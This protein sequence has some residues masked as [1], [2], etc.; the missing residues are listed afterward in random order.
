MGPSR[1]AKHELVA[2][3]DP[4]RILPT[5]RIRISSREKRLV[6]YPVDRDRRKTL[7]NADNA[8][9]QSI[10]S[11]VTPLPSASA[12]HPPLPPRPSSFPPPRSGLPSLS[13]L[14]SPRSSSSSSSS[15][16][17]SRFEILAPPSCASD[18]AR[19]ESSA[20]PRTIR[21]ERDSSNDSN[22][23]G[24][25]VIDRFNVSPLPRPL[26][27]LLLRSNILAHT[28]HANILFYSATQ[29]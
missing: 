21:I 24:L 2:L 1:S 5:L 25:T 22:R 18:R 16:P 29:P 6:V 17:G 9:F 13:L 20:V 26:A 23:I 19:G 12:I 4:Q 8:S 3:A 11:P 10:L 15:F 28:L 14:L 7:G 27:W